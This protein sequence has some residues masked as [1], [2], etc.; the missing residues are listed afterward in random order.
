MSISINGKAYDWADI[1]IKFPF[2]DVEAQSIEYGDELS[3]EVVYGQGNMP[4][5]YGVGNYSANCKLS[6]KL[7]DWEQVERHYG[8]GIYKV[9]IPKIIVSYANT[10]SRPRVDEITK[11]GITK[12]DN[13]ASQ[14]D[15]SLGVDVECLVAGMIIRNG[16]KPV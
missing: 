13:K 4:R 5:G 15:T 9:V 2:G 8:S 7:D 14:G 6:F 3:K 16:R 12:I 1:T 11:V 10:G